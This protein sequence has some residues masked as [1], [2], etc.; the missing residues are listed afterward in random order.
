MDI[1]IPSSI[2]SPISRGRAALAALAA[3]L[4]LVV[5]TGPALADPEETAYELRRAAMVMANGGDLVGAADH[6]VRVTGRLATDHPERDDNLRLAA[7]LYH[8]AGDLESAWRTMVNAGVAAYR[9]GDAVRAGNDLVDA[10][11]VAVEAGHASRAWDTAHKVGFV[12]RTAELGAAERLA[13]LERIQ[14]GSPG[15]VSG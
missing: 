8:H 4:L 6:L 11:V 15:L 2:P 13:I 12:L 3:V 9:L 10:T 7:R 1:P 5:T 14:V